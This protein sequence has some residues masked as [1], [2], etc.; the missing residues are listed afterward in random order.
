[1]IVCQSRS[2]L[3]SIDGFTSA[4]QQK[5]L[6]P[7]NSADKDRLSDEIALERLRPW[8]FIFSA[9]PDNHRGWLAQAT[10]AV[11][12]NVLTPV[13]DVIFNLKVITRNFLRKMNF[14]VAAHYYGLMEHSGQAACT[15]I[16]KA[17]IMLWKC[18]FENKKT[19]KKKGFLAWTRASHC[20]IIVEHT[21]KSEKYVTRLFVQGRSK[22]LS[23]SKRPRGQNWT[24]KVFAHLVEQGGISLKIS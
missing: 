17:F 4:Q 10:L 24:L 19:R 1:M 11:I 7:Y 15:Q 18:L 16:K 9:G 13:L 14:G 22:R 23:L 3:W 6:H 2:S 12:M 5:H 8:V 20:A 21:N